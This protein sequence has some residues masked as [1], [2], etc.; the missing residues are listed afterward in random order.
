MDNGTYACMVTL[1]PVRP[2]FVTAVMG[3]G[4]MSLAVQGEV[5]EHERRG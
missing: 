1:T 3:S 5:R 4:S 2:Q